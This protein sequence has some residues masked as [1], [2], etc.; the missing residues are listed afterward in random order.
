M[1]LA[2]A[3]TSFVGSEF[4]NFGGF[5]GGDKDW[6]ADDLGANYSM[7]WTQE[8]VKKFVNTPCTE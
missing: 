5:G 2:F 4:P 1:A 6:F 8:Q 7:D 3:G